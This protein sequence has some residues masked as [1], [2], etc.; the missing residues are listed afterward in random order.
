MPFLAIFYLSLKC[1]MQSG[2]TSRG[3]GGHQSEDNIVSHQ[4]VIT[5]PVRLAFHL[6][7]QPFFSGAPKSFSFSSS[8]QGIILGK[9]V[10]LK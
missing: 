3:I 5:I 4:P 7:E 9:C 8:E 10:R 1:L 6:H 2:G